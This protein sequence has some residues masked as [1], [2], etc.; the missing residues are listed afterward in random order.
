MKIAVAGATGN[1]GALTV[2]LLHGLDH[3]VVC[4]SR[5]HGTDLTVGEGLVDS[6]RGVTSVIDVSNIAAATR[7]ES[8]DRFGR[9]A[10]N[11]LDAGQRVGVRHH[12]LLSIL[13]VDRVDGNAHYAGK[14]EQERVVTSGSIPWTIVRAA[15]FHDFAEMVAGW[16]ER[17]GVA[18]IPPLLVQPIAPRDVAQLLVELALAA[19]ERRCID[20]A[21]PETQDLV[22]MAR[23]TYAARGR[24]VKLVPT[25]SSSFD[26]S[27]AGDVLLPTEGARIATT[28]FDEWLAEQRP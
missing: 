19:P 4:L 18:T 6:L 20:V 16:T 2:D 22:D 3:D 25:W 23:R 17:D 28:T 24:S 14:R 8:I 21:G 9:A 26:A 5:S 10:R 13:G 1:I 27:M 7:E 15:Q 12:V 11:L